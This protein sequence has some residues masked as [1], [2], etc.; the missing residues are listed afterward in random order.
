MLNLSGQPEPVRQ[1]VDRPFTPEENTQGVFAENTKVS[2][3]LPAER[4][5]I[6]ISVQICSMGYADTRY[7]DG[8]AYEESLGSV[9]EWRMD[10]MEM[11]T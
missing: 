1:V 4:R 7:R 5:D 11:G 9:I 8:M 2:Q 3:A 6:S 10:F